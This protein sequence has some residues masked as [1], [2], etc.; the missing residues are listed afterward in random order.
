MVFCGNELNLSGLENDFC[1]FCCRT[2]YGVRGLKSNCSR[3]RSHRPRS[4]SVWSAWI[5][6][7]HSLRHTH[8]SLSHSVWSAWIEIYSAFPFTIYVKRS[9]SVWS[10]WIE[11]KIELSET[12]SSTVSHSVWSAW[13]EIVWVRFRG[14]SITCRTPYGVRGL[15]CPAPASA[16]AGLLSHS[17]WSAWI[18]LMPTTE[19]VNGKPTSHSVWSAWIEMPRP[20]LLDTG[21]TSHSV[22]SAWIEIAW[23]P[24]AAA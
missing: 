3:H 17:V 7:P 12:V 19:Y 4:H 18:E 5:E 8:T 10:A 24:P 21:P 22:W 9:H 2:P 16:A 20:R 14:V 23:P 1:V 15:K 6:I 11:I 13:I